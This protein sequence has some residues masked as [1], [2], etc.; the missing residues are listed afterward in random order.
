MKFKFLTE[1]DMRGARA[2]IN[3]K[4]KPLLHEFVYAVTFW[5]GQ[6]STYWSKVSGSTETRWFSD[7]YDETTEI[8]VKHLM[9][10][11]DLD[12]RINDIG[13][14]KCQIQ[15]YSKGERRPTV[16]KTWKASFQ[17]QSIIKVYSA[18]LSA[19]K[20]DASDEETN[21]RDDTDDKEPCTKPFH[22]VWA[23]CIEKLVTPNHDCFIESDKRSFSMMSFSSVMHSHIIDSIFDA[24]ELAT[25]CQV[26]SIENIRW[27][28]SIPISLFAP[29]QTRPDIRTLHLHI[30]DSFST[31]R[32]V[33]HKYLIL[34]NL[35]HLELRNVSDFSLDSI[36]DLVETNRMMLEMMVVDVE[37]NIFLVDD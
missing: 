31:N 35:A 33:A 4:S 2:L 17:L 27:E 6:K 18:L 29:R 37:K 12:L 34:A 7:L 1:A 25:A 10:K 23:D 11:L 15:R 13:L 19:P 22:Q 21:Q 20:L 26:L 3:E 28:N 9:E 5:T 30:S 16:W 8:K 36:Y 24:L 32:Q 14:F